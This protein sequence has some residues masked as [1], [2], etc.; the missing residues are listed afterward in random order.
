MSNLRMAFCMRAVKTLC[1]EDLGALTDGIEAYVQAG[2]PNAQAA[3]AAVR[4]LTAAVE[5]ER[6]E[7]A[8]LLRA[9]HPQCFE[10]P[11]NAATM[12]HGG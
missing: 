9:Q 3:P 2:M 7:M 5:A 11:G 6:C 4:D 1:D 8:L 10:K 12:P